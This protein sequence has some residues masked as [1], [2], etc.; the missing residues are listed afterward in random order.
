[1]RLVAY[2]RILQAEVESRRSDMSGIAPVQVGDLIVVGGHWVGEPRRTGE[3]LE[4][5]GTP[6]TSISES[7]GTTATRRSSIPAATPFMQHIEHTDTD[8]PV[9]IHEP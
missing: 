1:M 6:D 4:V 9:L 7:G 8:G 2:C 3:I 5:L